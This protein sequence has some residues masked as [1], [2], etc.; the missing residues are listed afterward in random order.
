MIGST[1]PV[2]GRSVELPADH[3]GVSDLAYRERRGAIAE[4]GERYR[5]GDPIP[6]VE[7]TPEEDDVWRV[8][9]R[10]LGAKHRRYACRA[11]LDGAAAL[12]LP[13]E[14]VPQ[15]R[16]VDERVHA[17]TGFHIE[18]VP[19]L[20]PTR[21]FYGSLARRTF[22]STQ[23]IR[24][25]SVP[26]YTPEPDVVHEII[27]HANMLANPVLADLYE[28]AG[29]A[30]IRV[31]D[32]DDELQYFSRVFWFSLEFG[33]VHEGGELKAYGAGLLSSFGEIDVFR[34]AEVRP[35]DIEQMGTLDYDITQYQPVLFA[36]ESFDRMVHDLTAFFDG[37]G[38]R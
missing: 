37:F 19:G 8:V 5:S 10:E 31:A 32:H 13:T 14:R 6:D 25:H 35:W 22:L 29:R 23:Y 24:H 30:S 17:L 16:E 21:M 26:F 34:A 15:L 2:V 18:P 4:A 1:S 7:Y 28:V 36:A 9:A 20:V 11:Y 33:V 12:T 27:G 38:R 3:P